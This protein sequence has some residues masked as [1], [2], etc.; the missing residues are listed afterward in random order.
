M[1][2]NKKIINKVECFFSTY[3]II[4]G[5][6]ISILAIYTVELIKS[7]SVDIIIPLLSKEH[8]IEHSTKKL[9]GKTIKTGSFLT[10]LIRYFLT[11]IIVMLVIYRFPLD[12][13]TN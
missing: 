9:L 1:N 7:L 5:I 8:N 13:L 2:S 12:K 10:T 6:T 4:V 11:I 3:N